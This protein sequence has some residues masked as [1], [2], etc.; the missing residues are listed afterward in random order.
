MDQ[1]KT[2]SRIPTIL[3]ICAILMAMLAGIRMYYLY[4]DIFSGGE[5]S[6]ISG[7]LS[8]DSIWP[9]ISD[10]I[11]YTV[12]FGLIVLAAFTVYGFLRRRRWSLA[13]VVIVVMC[14]LLSLVLIDVPPI[15]LVLYVDYYGYGALS[16]IALITAFFSWKH[17]EKRENH[18]TQI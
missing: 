11:Y 7:F 10:I 12:R 14:N 13:V 9:D 2:Q 17:L 1:E 5:Y 4:N 3:V 16:I 15:G 18:G 6:R 8:S